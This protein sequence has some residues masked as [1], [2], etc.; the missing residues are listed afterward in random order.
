MRVGNFFAALILVNGLFV[1]TAPVLLAQ[2]ASAIR[3][4]LAGRQRMLSQRMAAASCL[5]LI[6]VGGAERRQV[7]LAAHD[8]FATALVALQFGQ[9]SL[10]LPAENHPDIRAAFQDVEETWRSYGPAIQ[11]LAHGDQH[12]VVVL[13]LLVH[14]VTALARSNAAVQHIVKVHGDSGIDPALSKAINL[15]GRQRMLSQRM[16]KDACFVS[17]GID[18]EGS[19]T[20]LEQSMKLFQETLHNLIR[21]NPSKGI[22]APPTP[23]VARQLQVVSAQWKDFSVALRSVAPIQGGRARDLARLEVVA[24]MSDDILAASHR[25]VQLYVQSTAHP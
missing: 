13:Q 1:T 18:T 11:Q 22:A 17:V 4:N 19:A 23:G 20:D 5:A 15:A 3:I 21:G 2:G 12:S 6:G 14:N 8:D 9:N 25:A 10:G 16:M 24:Q 7:A